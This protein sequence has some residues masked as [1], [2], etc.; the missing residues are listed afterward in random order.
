VQNDILPIKLKYLV[1]IEKLIIEFLHPSIEGRIA[2][3]KPITKI[4]LAND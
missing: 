3:D 1:S 2:K 4:I